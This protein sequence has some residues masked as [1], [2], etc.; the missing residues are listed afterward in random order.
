M[1][2]RRISQRAWRLLGPLGQLI[3]CVVLLTIQ[4]GCA[5]QQQVPKATESDLSLARPLYELALLHLRDG[6]LLQARITLEQALSFAQDQPHYWNSLGLV[7]LQLRQFQ[8]AQETFRKAIALNPHYADAYNNLGVALGQS[9]QWQEAIGA[10]EKALGIP[11]YNTP[12][13]VYQ[14]MGWSYYNLGRYEEAERALK[15]AL[16]IDPKLATAHHTLGLLYEKQG[17][18]KEALEAY[19]QALQ[20]APDSEPGR[21][22]QE[23][24]KALGG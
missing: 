13:V 21:R 8:K 14:N 17:R 3:A 19:R 23:R 18:Q 5:P 9:N 16:Q 15:S 20:L 10:F 24:I 6:Q 11:T 2:S 4:S 7:E 22:S 1:T 12:E